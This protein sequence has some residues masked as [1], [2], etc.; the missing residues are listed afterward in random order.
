YIIEKEGLDVGVKRF[1]SLSDLHY[2]TLQQLFYKGYME[3]L[4]DYIVNVNKGKKV[5]AILIPGD[6]LFWLSNYQEK[7][8]VKALKRDLEK[9]SYSLSAPI[10]ISY[11]NHDL[12]FNEST[13]TDE[14]KKEWDLAQYIENTSEGIYVLNNEQKRFDNVVV[15]GFSPIRDAYATSAMPDKAIEMAKETFDKCDF[16]FDKKDLNIL[17]SHENKFFTYE[18]ATSHYG[19]LYD[20]I[21]FI[22]G[23]HLHDGYMPIWL[24]DIFKEQLKDRGI[25]EKIPMGIDMCRGAFKVNKSITSEVIL[26]EKGEYTDINLKSNETASIVNRGVAKYS[27][28]IPSSP[29]MVTIEVIPENPR[30]LNKSIR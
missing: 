23:G 15:T 10:C 4:F 16:T 26:P 30:S 2:G 8:F 1:V 9:L 25:W 17:M 6:L 27:W 14:E 11:G 29:S 5:D 22:I 13:L 24:Q 19:D 7:D 18:Q 12:P 21:T 3:K 20:Y 28:F